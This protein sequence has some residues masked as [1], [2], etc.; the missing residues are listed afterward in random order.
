[1]SAT[2]KTNVVIIDDHHLARK[3]IREILATDDTFTICA[4]G[5]NAS[6]AM[7]LAALHE[8]ALMLIDIH[9][10]GTNGLEA[11]R[12]IKAQYPHIK[13]VIITVSD[14]APYLFEALKCGAQGYLL[15]NLQAD[16]WLEYLRSLFDT[17]T[18]VSPSLAASILSEFHIQPPSHNDALQA[19][20]AQDLAILTE[21]ER[22]I[23]EWVARGKTNRD[24]AER[25]FLS[26]NTVKNHLKSILH[27]L[28]LQNRV[29]LTRVAMERGWV[30]KTFPGKSQKS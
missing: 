17:Q 8:P 9:M 30:E 20:I 1:V 11:T 2:R 12:Q 24:I 7:Q 28:H 10:P 26:E 3:A 18:T 5:K 15:K 4:E 21:R 6:D 16:R 27:K 14:Q 13:I 25:L 29:H 19:E 23:L 22:E